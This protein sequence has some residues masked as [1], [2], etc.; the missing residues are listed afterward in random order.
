M[1]TKIC[2]LALTVL[3]AIAS[4]EIASAAQLTAKPGRAKDSITA[5]LAKARAG[6]IIVAEPGVY[7]GSSETFPLVMKGGVTL[8][9]LDAARTVIDAGAARAFEGESGGVTLANLTV[10]AGSDHIFF[11]VPTTGRLVIRDSIF[12][13]QV[14]GTI[15]VRN[16]DGEIIIDGCEV[17]G[18]D[19][20]LRLIGTSGLRTLEVTIKDTVLRTNQP[21][22]AKENAISGANAHS[23]TLTDMTVYDFVENFQGGNID[24]MII[25]NLNGVRSFNG[26][27]DEVIIRDSIMGRNPSGYPY[28][29]IS[30][31]GTTKIIN[32]MLVGGDANQYPSGPVILLNCYDENLVPIP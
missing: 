7:D 31:S 5:A 1:K 30:N 15:T 8:M 32:T 18:I 25:E 11:D 3:F 4:S 24:E 17:A 9:G 19:A 10:L 21:Q 12:D 2:A 13:T 23:F 6:D 22:P 28:Q 27:V 20:P 14:Y 16:N 29:W 26:N